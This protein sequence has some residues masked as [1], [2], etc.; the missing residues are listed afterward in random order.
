MIS[1]KNA[2]HSSTFYRGPVQCHYQ[3]VLLPSESDQA[4]GSLSCLPWLSYSDLCTGHFQNAVKHLLTVS[5]TVLA[6]H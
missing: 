5:S 6:A 4:A 1:E 2:E 3:S